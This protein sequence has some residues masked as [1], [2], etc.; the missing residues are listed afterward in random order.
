MQVIST[1][2]FE[3]NVSFCNWI[4]FAEAKISTKNIYP[5]EENTLLAIESETGN[6]GS[7]QAD[8]M[9]YKNSSARTPALRTLEAHQEDPLNNLKTTEFASVPNLRSPSLNGLY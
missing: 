9:L 1:R 7:Y 8:G 3:T 4:Y 6:Q 5:Q 2:R